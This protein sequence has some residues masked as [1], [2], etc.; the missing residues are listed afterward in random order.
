MDDIS[1]CT[2][3][4]H[5]QPIPKSVGLEEIEHDVSRGLNQSSTCRSSSVGYL[6]HESDLV[7]RS[8]DDCTISLD[9]L[10]RW[11]KDVKLLLKQ[12]TW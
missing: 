9:Q 1:L 6:P 4:A 12:N 11:L 7:D 5:A 2:R 8:S 3:L 10:L